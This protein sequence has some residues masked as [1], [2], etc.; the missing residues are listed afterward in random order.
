MSS[1]R[2][3]IAASLL[4]LV[5]LVW[6]APAPLEAQQPKKG[7][8]L[9]VGM[10]GDPTSL[11]PGTSASPAGIRVRNAIYETLLAWDRELRL[12]PML[13]DRYEVSADGLTY[14]FHLRKGIVF[15]DGSPL[16]AEDVKFTYERALKVS[17]R[18]AD[19]AMIEAI[20]VVDPHTVRF[21]LKSAGALFLQATASWFTQITPKR[22]TEQQLQKSGEI[23]EPVGTGPFRFVEWRRGQHIKL[24]RFADYKPRPEPPGGLAGAKIA[25]LDEVVFVPIKDDR[26]R[27]LSLEQGEVDYAQQVPAE[28]ADRLA[29]NTRLKVESVPGTNWTSIYFNTGMA[30]TSSKAFRQAVAIA[31]DYDQINRA[32]FWGRGTVNHSLLPAALA[33]WRT[34]EHA[35]GYR[36]DTGRAR[37]LLQQ[38]GYKGEEIVLET[39]NEPD[40]EL[41]SQNLQAQLRKVG[42]NVRLN[43]LESAAHIGSLYSR[44]RQKRPPTWHIGLLAN[45]VF[46]PDP[47][48][49]YYPRGH[50]QFH[51]G[52]W[53]NARYDALVEKARASRDANERRK[54]YAEAHALHIEEVP[55]IVLVNEPYIEAYARHVKGVQVLDP[56]QD[57][58]W[59]VWLDR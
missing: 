38:A 4:A 18:K 33:L 8:T 22:A 16:S 12:Q 36:Q 34:P 7:G 29:S 45:S 25:Y 43:T 52:F 50:S 51:V 24:V 31:I 17:H 21:K 49:Y 35:Q 39:R 15:H 14:T 48:M 23:L 42:I 28:E 6:P 47:D 27:M 3:L 53:Q 54:L 37:Q 55:F 2:G 56:H 1:P 59:G 57:I 30:P 20:E 44:A 11:D 32:A 40:Y 46:R 58:Y 5:A 19:L 26:I 13:A 9:R 10:L 41:V